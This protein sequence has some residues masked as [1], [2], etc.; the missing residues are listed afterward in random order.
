ALI[1]ARNS[2]MVARRAADLDIDLLLQGCRDKGAALTDICARLG[3]A[4]SA[5]CFM[6]DDLADLPALQLAGL[7]VAPA[8]AVGWI[9]ERV[10][11]VTAKCGGDGAARELC[12]L[13][14]DAQGHSAAV[15]AR[16]GG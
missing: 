12:E 2:P 3:I 10:H 4:T 13:L 11:L 7:S 1:T 6:G 16:Y 5:A 8:N 15:L 9:R 14:L